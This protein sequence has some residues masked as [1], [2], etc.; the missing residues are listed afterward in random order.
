MIY[1]TD[2][3]RLLIWD[4]SAWV[5]YARVSSSENITASTVTTTGNISSSGAFRS[6]STNIIQWVDVGPLTQEFQYTGGQA[7]SITLSTSIPTNARYIWASVYI[8][9]TS[10]D[11][12]NFEFS[13]SSCATNIKNWVDSARGNRPLTEMGDLT[14]RR[15]VYLTSPGEND[16]FSSWYGLWH[17]LMIPISNRTMFWTNFGNSGSNGWVA[18]KILCYSI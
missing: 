18:L 15:S 13:N 11:H 3:D 12:Q 2:T 1:E 10:G 14:A 16:A 17:N 5:V 8:N 6:G 4:N 7:S 9:T